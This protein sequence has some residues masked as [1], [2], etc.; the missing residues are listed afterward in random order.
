MDYKITTKT[1]PTFY[2]VGVTTGKS[3]V[4]KVFPLWMDVL[5]KPEVVLEGIDHAI[6][7]V[8]ENYKKTAA[9]IFH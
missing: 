3:S 8:P 2:F 4:N 9:Y 6:H 1:V 5:G 7:D